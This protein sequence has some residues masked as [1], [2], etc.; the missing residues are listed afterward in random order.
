[1]VQESLHDAL[2]DKPRSGRP[3]L[4]TGDT[5]AHLI[6][7]ACSTPPAGRVVWTLR[8]LAERVVE[9]GYIEHLSTTAVMKRLKKTNSSPGA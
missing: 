3:P 1:L 9:L 6:A 7:L 5:E 2:Y 4:I 8:L